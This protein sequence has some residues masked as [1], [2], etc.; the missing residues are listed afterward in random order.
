MKLKSIL[1]LL[2]LCLANIS[3]AQHVYFYTSGSRNVGKNEITI[4]LSSKKQ[5]DTKYNMTYTW[6]RI[7]V[8]EGTS[9]LK[10]NSSKYGDIESIKV[11]MKKNDVAFYEID[12]SNTSI[13]VVEKQ[14]KWVSSSVQSDY[15]NIKHNRELKERIKNHPK[16]NWDQQKLKKYF[17]TSTDTIEGIYEVPYIDGRHPAYILGIIKNKDNGFDIIYLDGSIG[18][19]WKKGDLKGS[20]IRTGAKNVFRLNW[21]N[22]DKTLAEK[23]YAEYHEGRIN[24]RISNSESLYYLKMYPYFKE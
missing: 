6:I 11:D 20:L 15:N 21:Y 10:V 24:L 2:F 19:T 13:K 18:N 9:T 8:A 17:D 23:K 3:F 1:L 16:T 4:L 22:E 5:K 14:E 12:A 7:D